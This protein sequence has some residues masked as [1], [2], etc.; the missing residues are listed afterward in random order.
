MSINLVN[1]EAFAEIPEKL[2]DLKKLCKDNSFLDSEDANTIFDLCQRFGD[3]NEYTPE[4]TVKVTP[5]KI[6]YGENLVYHYSMPS[7]DIP[8]IENYLH[9]VFDPDGN[10]IDATLW[11][12]SNESR[13]EILTNHWLYNITKSGKFTI[14]F[15]K[16]YGLSYPTGEIVKTAFFE[17][18]NNPSPLVQY[19]RG[20]KPEF[21]HCN[22]EFEVILKSNNGFPACVKPETIPKLIER[23]WTKPH[24]LTVYIFPGNVNENSTQFRFDNYT[25]PFLRLPEFVGKPI[26]TNYPLGAS[27]VGQHND[28]DKIAGKETV[29]IVLHPDLKFSN[30]TKVE[31]EDIS[32]AMRFGSGGKSSSL[33][34]KEEIIGATFIVIKSQYDPYF[35]PRLDEIYRMLF[36]NE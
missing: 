32:K 8:D 1:F 34:L 36:E 25:H 10:R 4:I 29:R 33:L 28:G 11:G 17:I 20:V 7:Y 24:N 15:E 22:N 12:A 21:V 27:M 19:E 13:Y 9:E 31:I 16:T 5:D 18:I 3:S 26:F 30:G 2:E 6:K 35:E 14:T 23:G